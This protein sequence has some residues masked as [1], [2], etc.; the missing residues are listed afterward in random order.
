MFVAVLDVPDE[1]FRVEQTTDTPE[2]FTLWGDADAL[3]QCVIA[4]TPA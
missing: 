2:H 4:I 1:G 3:L